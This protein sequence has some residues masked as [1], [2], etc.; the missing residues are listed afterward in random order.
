SK[1]GVDVLI[2]N[3]TDTTKQRTVKKTEKKPSFENEPDLLQRDKDKTPKRTTCTNAGPNDDSVFDLTASN[4]S[5]NESS[6]SQRPRER[7]RKKCSDSGAVKFIN[8][9]TVIYSAGSQSENSIVVKRTVDLLK[10][11]LV[12]SDLWV[13]NESVSGVLKIIFEKAFTMSTIV[14]WFRKCDVYP[15]NPNATDNYLLLR[16]CEDISAGNYDLTKNVNRQTELGN[17]VPLT[18]NHV[19]LMAQTPATRQC[20]ICRP[21][22]IPTFLCEISLVSLTL[23]SAKTVL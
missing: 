13:S 20:L 10:A 1:R 3:D 11:K 4:E 17:E 16:S 22:P 7:F 6:D 21:T 12:K 19:Q 15:F 2:G 8:G 23:W 5:L 9:R 14:E 18:T